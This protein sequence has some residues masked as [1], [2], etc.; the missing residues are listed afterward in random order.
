[1]KATELVKTSVALS[2]IYRQITEANARHEFKV[3][4]PHWVYVSDACKLELVHNGFKI[5][6]GEWLHGDYGL[7]IEW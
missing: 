1:M 5:S 7:I 4:Y 6:N 2:E 3:F